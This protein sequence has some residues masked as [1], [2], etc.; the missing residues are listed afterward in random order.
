MFSLPGDTSLV[1]RSANCG[2]VLNEKESRSVS[3]HHCIIRYDKKSDVFRFK[4]ISSKGSKINTVEIHWRQ[5]TLSVGDLIQIGGD[6]TGVS[7][8]FKLFSAED[9]SIKKVTV[10]VPLLLFVLFDTHVPPADGR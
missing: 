8:V 3:G 7:F 2:L 1:R 10:V 5:V 9:Q 4:D 6:K